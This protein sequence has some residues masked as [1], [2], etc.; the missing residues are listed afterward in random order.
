M[1]TNQEISYYRKQINSI[2]RKLDQLAFKCA[3]KDP[4]IKGSPGRIYRQCGKKTCKF[5]QGTHNRH[6][7]YYV[8]QIQKNGRQ[9]QI[10]LGKSVEEAWLKVTSYQ[11]QMRYLKEIKFCSEELIAM[12]E[13]VINKRTEEYLS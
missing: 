9:R 11:K 4:L 13:N 1:M 5:S 6:G 12:V 7:P 10:F 8:I 3:H 2:V